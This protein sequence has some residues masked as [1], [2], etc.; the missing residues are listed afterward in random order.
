MVTAAQ[1]VVLVTPERAVTAVYLVTADSQDSVDLVDTAVLQAARAIRDSADS[2]A[3][4][5]TAVYL[6]IAV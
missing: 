1:Q 6:A 3:F 2:V 5:A 4:R